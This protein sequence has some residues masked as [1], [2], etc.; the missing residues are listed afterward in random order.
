MEKIVKNAKNMILMEKY[1]YSSISC[2][3]DHQLIF[4]SSTFFRKEGKLLALLVFSSFRRVAFSGIR[5]SSVATSS[6]KWI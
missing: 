1:I 4:L 5:N 3:F 6:S 2:S